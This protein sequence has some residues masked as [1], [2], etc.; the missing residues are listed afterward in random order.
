MIDI[1]YIRENKEEVLK[2]V[3]AKC[4]DADIDLLLELDGKRGI[5]RKEIEKLNAERK[6]AAEA[7]NVNRGKEIKI[8]LAE[9]ESEEKILEEKIHGIFYRVRT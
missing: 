8:S 7:K 9:I 4:F 5:L 6:K 2:G 3:K 1:K